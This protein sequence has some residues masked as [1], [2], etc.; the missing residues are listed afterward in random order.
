MRQTEDELTRDML[1]ATASFINCTA[2]SNGDSPTE[3]KDN[4]DVSEVTR[5]LLSANAYTIFDK[6][7]AT[8]QISTVA[9]RDAYYAMCSTDL[10][11]EFDTNQ[12]FVHKSKYPFG[13]QPLRQ[14]WGAIGNLR[15]LVSSIGSKSP[16]ASAL[17]ADVYNIICAGME[18]YAIVEQN[19]YSSK[20]IYRPGIYDSALALNATLGYKMAQVPR[21]LNDAWVFNLRCTLSA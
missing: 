21:I 17:G 12:Y 6:I 13:E 9:V 11:A 5:S 14:E 1:V 15:F 18:S 4:L 10:T 20:L 19:M 2:G 7:T 8:D 16:N 3:L